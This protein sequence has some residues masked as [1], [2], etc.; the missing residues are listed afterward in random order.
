MSR[1]AGL[2]SALITIAA[3]AC[4]TV[5]PARINA[6]D[7]CF[8]CRRTITDTNL[9][10][11]RVAGFV[12]KFRAPGCMAKYIVTHPDETGP[13]FD[14][15]Y[16]TGKMMSPDAAFFVP[17]VLDAISGETD[18]RAYHLKVEADQAAIV[19]HTVP[20]TWQTVLDRARQ[21]A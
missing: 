14:T 13:I 4:A 8:R 6:G 15:D 18:Y 9:A 20:V 1:T 11:E 2:C 7:Q 19:F 3:I 21:G 5:A 17:I 10:A 16:G 12:E